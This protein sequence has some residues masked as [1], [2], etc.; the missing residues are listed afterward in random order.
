[1]GGN[2]TPMA[3]GEVITSLSQGTIDALDHSLGVFNDFQLHEI[4]PI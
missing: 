2:P 4:A 1:M 3:W